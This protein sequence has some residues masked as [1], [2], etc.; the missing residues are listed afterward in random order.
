MRCSILA[1][2]LSSVQDRPLR[3]TMVSSKD[4]RVVW[5]DGVLFTVRNGLDFVGIPSLRLEDTR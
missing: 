3:C 2:R 1:C 4:A 5:A